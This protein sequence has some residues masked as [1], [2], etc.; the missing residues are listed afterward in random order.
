M[1][2]FPARIRESPSSFTRV[3]CENSSMYVHTQTQARYDEKRRACS[4]S[5]AR[6]FPLYIRFCYSAILLSSIP[7]TSTNA[8][9]EKRANVYFFS[10]L[11]ME[12]RIRAAA[13]KRFLRTHVL[14][15]TRDEITIY[16][17][18]GV[19]RIPLSPSLGITRHGPRYRR[20][21]RKSYIYIY[22]RVVIDTR[23]V[24]KG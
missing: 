12:G 7:E 4:F 8:I 17:V 18:I 5:S 20:I 23:R 13:L 22:I 24:R 21:L 15:D 6:K 1:I 9:S 19:T 14:R 10:H 16:H 3:D 2:T 11:E